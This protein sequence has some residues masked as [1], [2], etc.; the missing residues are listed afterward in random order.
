MKVCELCGNAIDTRDGENRCDEC[1]DNPAMRGRGD[2]SETAKAK[3]KRRNAN[4]RA[5]DDAMRS[6]GLTKVRG[7]MGGTYWE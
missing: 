4:R 3:R 2:T 6:L 5:M 7:A 1:A